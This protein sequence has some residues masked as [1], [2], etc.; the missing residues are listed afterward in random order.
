MKLKERKIINEAIEVIRPD[1]I[2]ALFIA[3]GHSDTQ[4]YGLYSA[5]DMLTLA[6]IMYSKPGST[7]NLKR[8]TETTYEMRKKDE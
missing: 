6:D 2:V 8:T 3:E 4:E 1:G 5:G 7:I